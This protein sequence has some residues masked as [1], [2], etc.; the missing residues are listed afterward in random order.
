MMRSFIGLL[1][2]W[3]ISVVAATPPIPQWSVVLD[4]GNGSVEFNAVGRPSAIKIKGKGTNAKGTLTLE[5]N[6][7]SGI[8]I[9]AL[10]SLDTGI[11]LRNEHM[12]TKYLETEKFPEARLTLSQITLPESFKGD[13][14]MAENV[15]FE[16]KL[17]LHGVE[18]LVKGNASVER[19]GAE[20][21]LDAVF[22]LK[23]SDFA[24]ATPGFAGI[25]MA[26]DVKVIVR[27]TAPISVSKQ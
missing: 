23:I 12:K 10:D 15:P 19:K 20:V 1:S 9:F 7:V 16:G 8:A 18:K 11:K 22:D 5:G 26:E 13:V 17:L 27:T 21:T 2:L 14:A 25:T 6:R 3:G 4:Q 24:I